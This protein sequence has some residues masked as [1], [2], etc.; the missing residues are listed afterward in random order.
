MQDL[1]LSWADAVPLTPSPAPPVPTLSDRLCQLSSGA[2]LTIAAII[3]TG[4]TDTPAPALSSAALVGDGT[5]LSCHSELEAYATTAH[6][7]TSAEA[8]AAAIDGSFEEGQNVLATA[9][10]NLHYRMEALPDGR[11]RQVAFV[12]RAEP[13]SVSGEA[14]IDVVVGSGRKGQTYLHWQ[15]DG[16]FQLPVS[17]WTGV[18][19]ANSPGY[20]SGVAI[21]NRPVNPRCLECHATFAQAVDAGGQMVDSFVEVRLGN[22]VGC[23]VEGKVAHQ[24]CRQVG[25]ENVGE[26]SVEGMATS[27]WLQGASMRE[28]VAGFNAFV[29][30]LSSNELLRRPSPSHDKARGLFALGAVP[31]LSPAMPAPSRTER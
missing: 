16:L 1:A 3:T 13:F 6:A 24:R 9:N 7:R 8:T 11:F 19:W 20:P 2:L 18:G 29:G 31:N 10:P 5:C 25:A 22:Q 4:C 12:G 14:A 15:G 27:F 28:A 21:F 23:G 30:C 17:H 26:A